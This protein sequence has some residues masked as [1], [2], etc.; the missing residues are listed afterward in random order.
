MCV[1]PE[2]RAVE[3]FGLTQHK[4]QRFAVGWAS[5]AER[6][7]RGANRPVPLGK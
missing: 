7:Q 2:D 1:K 3:V 4:M 6:L 5:E